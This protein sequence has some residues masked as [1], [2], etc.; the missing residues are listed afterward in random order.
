MM[1]PSQALLFALRQVLPDVAD[2]VLHRSGALYCA[3]TERN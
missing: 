3:P 2:A 1:P